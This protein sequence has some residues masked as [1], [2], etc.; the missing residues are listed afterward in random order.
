[1][2]KR[3]RLAE[4]A[5][6]KHDLERPI[7]PAVKKPDGCRHLLASPDKETEDRISKLENVQAHLQ[8]VH[9]T[10]TSK[11]KN[12]EGKLLEKQWEKRQAQR[13]SPPMMFMNLE[14]EPLIKKK[15]C[16]TRRKKTKE[17]LILTKPI[18]GVHYHLKMKD[19]PF[20]VGKV[21]YIND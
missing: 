21:S 5:N 18:P 2:K 6:I 8:D 10:S 14:N 4:A 20:V 3:L 13:H 12:L 7:Q 16:P 11:I 15:K 19:V 9:E 1:M 17:S